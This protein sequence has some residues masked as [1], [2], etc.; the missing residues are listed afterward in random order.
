MPAGTAGNASGDKLMDDKHRNILRRFRKE[1]AEDM[2]PE[3]V[4]RQM[5]DPHLFTAE[6]EHKVKAEKT[7]LDQCEKFLDML[8]RKGDRAYG[9]FMETIGKVHPHLANV[10][11]SAGTWLLGTEI[12]LIRGEWW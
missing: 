1:L 2:E 3:K 10:I 9:I 11:L 4:L 5:V 12:L 8:V 6:D 7:R